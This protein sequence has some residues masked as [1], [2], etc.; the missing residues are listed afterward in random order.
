MGSIIFSPDLEVFDLIKSTYSPAL[1]LTKSWFSA[2]KD[3]V[4][5]RFRLSLSLI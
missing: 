5:S 4:L 3:L 1:D 2:G